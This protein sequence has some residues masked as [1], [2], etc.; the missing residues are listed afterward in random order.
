M[1]LHAFD[2]QAAMAQPHDLAVLGRGAD[3]EARGQAVA[4]HDQRVIARRH[5]FL[6]QGLENPLPIM[7]DARHLAVH[8]LPG[9]H[10]RAAER[11]SDRLVP[12][13]HA[14]DR[15]A[16]REPLDR[17]ERD[18]CLVRRARAGGKHDMRGCERF[19]FRHVELVVAEH[20][21]LRAELAEVLH[22]VEGERI[23][24]V[25]HQ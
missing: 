24:V 13:A 14:E 3:L 17:L 25:D 15:D 18:A 2:R 23:V 10:H 16:A 1:K 20:L 5:E 7:P 11:L 9:A 19:D 22:Q 8:H 4:L 6:W 21:H 12:E